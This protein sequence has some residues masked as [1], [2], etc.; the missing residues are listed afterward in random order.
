M[1]YRPVLKAEVA[2]YVINIIV[3]LLPLCKTA[4]YNLSF[5]FKVKSNVE[6]AKSHA[7]PILLFDG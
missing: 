1:N 7:I 4:N 3:F 2:R 5:F 6:K